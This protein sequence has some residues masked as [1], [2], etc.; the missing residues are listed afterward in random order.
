MADDLFEEA[1]PVA[2]RVA[3]YWGNRTGLPAEE[4]L[5]PAL[6]GAWR[7]AGR[8]DPARGPLDRYAAGLAYGA[9]LDWLR[10]ARGGG[11][12]NRPPPLGLTLDLECRGRAELAPLELRDLLNHARRKL[13][14]PQRLAL[15]LYYDEG[16]TGQEIGAATGCHLSTALSRVRT[17]LAEMRTTLEGL[18]GQG[19]G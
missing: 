14:W 3:R 15:R 4:L 7:A 8:Y 2:E 19:V 16:M 10:L 18:H 17:A 12:G 6:E 1:R 11:R 5:G 9:V 13:S